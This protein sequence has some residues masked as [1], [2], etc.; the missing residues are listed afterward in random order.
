MEY[1][2]IKTLS[3]IR[4]EIWDIQDKVQKERDAE[5]YTF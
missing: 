4:E 3:D 2:S 5:D 1:S